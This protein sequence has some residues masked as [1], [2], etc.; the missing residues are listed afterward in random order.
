ML[1]GNKTLQIS[2][3]LLRE[4]DDF[5]RLH[6]AFLEA[7]ADYIVPFGLT[8]EQLKNHIAINAV[9]LS[10]SIGAFDGEKMIGFTLNAFGM[11]NGERTVYDAGTGVVPDFRVRGIGEKMFEFMRL[12]LEEANVRQILL[13]VINGNERAIRLYRKIGFCE[14]RK[15]LIFE[16][17]KPMDFAARFAQDFEIRETET[18]D[19]SLFKSFWDANPSWQNSAE[20]L[21]RS[22]SPKKIITAVTRRKICVGYAVFFPKSGFAAQLAV[23]KNH[24]RRGI[25]SLILSEMRRLSEKEKPLRVNN[26]DARLINAVEFFKNRGFVETLS[27][28]EMIKIL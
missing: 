9:D 19:W 4:P 26:V 27:Q 14:A 24:R 25:G 11:W 15:L 17:K 13:E 8:K 1:K 21:E 18:A 2:Y 20:A 23:D 5:A 28:S 3:R 22:P 6:A 12:L 16:Q 10:K 7:F